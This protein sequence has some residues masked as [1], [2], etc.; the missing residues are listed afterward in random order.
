ME[1]T[2]F[3][4][5]ISRHPLLGGL[6]ARYKFGGG[7]S[8]PKIAPAPAPVPR[9]VEVDVAAAE[10]EQRTISSRRRGRFQSVLTR[11]LDFGRA[12]T[13]RAELLGL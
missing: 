9:R 13:S 5:E 10:R 8:V 6:D 12:E 1:I 3:Y 11:D 2:L 7:G 4:D